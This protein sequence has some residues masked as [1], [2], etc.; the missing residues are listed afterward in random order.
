M[1]KSRFLF[2]CFGLGAALL[3]SACGEGYV[4]EVYKGV[5][6]TD[7]RT[8]HSGVAYVRAKMAPPAGPVIEPQM[9]ETI[10]EEPAVMPVAEPEPMPAP[11]PEPE[12]ESAD[13]LFI[14]DSKK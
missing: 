10:V 1:E 4:T 3:L 8:A 11:M 7:E 2:S 13:P 14:M 12:L 5:P 6:Y 9:Q